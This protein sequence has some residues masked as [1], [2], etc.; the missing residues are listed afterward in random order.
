MTSNLT[1]WALLA[2]SLLGCAALGSACAANGGGEDVDA[3]ADELRKCADGPTLQ[4]IDVSKYQ[5]T[6][7]WVKVK[8][9]GKTF[10][11]A[12]VSD[13]IK[14]PDAYFASN[15]SKMKEAGLIR[16]VY[17]FFRASVD[18][19][20]QAQLLIDDVIAAGGLQPGDLPPALDLETSD[21][22]GASTVAARAQQWLTKVESA[23]GIRPIV[24]TGNN[25]NSVTGTKFS[26]YALWVPNYGASC[27][28]MPP[29]WTSWKF[30]QDSQTGRCSGVTGA[31]DTN[32][33][34]GTLDALRALTVPATA[35]DVDAG[36]APPVTP[37]DADA[38]AD[39]A[40]EEP[41]AAPSKDGAFGATMGSFA[42]E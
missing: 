4:G 8:A 12:R 13:G 18:A 20:A 23:F 37:D 22:V 38:G 31:V 26:S 25:M 34:N 29:G 11:F 24:Y 35:S 10:A 28:L 7:D 30:W 17:Q 16:G 36:A 33:F 9:A 39:E 19:N 2:C 27:P 14:H 3:T 6:V 15:W 21:G 1:K 32:F 40:G 5:E 42:R 41:A